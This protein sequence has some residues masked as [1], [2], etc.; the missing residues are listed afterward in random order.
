MVLYHTITFHTVVVTALDACCNSLVNVSPSC[1]FG[2]WVWNCT[3]IQP[4]ANAAFFR[5][6]LY[7]LTQTISQQFHLSQNQLFHF[8][9]TLGV[10]GNYFGR[11]RNGMAALVFPRKPC[12]VCSFWVLG[13]SK[14]LLPSR[15]NGWLL[16]HS[17]DTIK[18]GRSW[19]HTEKLTLLQSGWLII[20]E[21]CSVKIPLQRTGSDWSKLVKNIKI[22]FLFHATLFLNLK[23]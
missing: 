10:T 21:R 22:S 7:K 5:L 16:C 14:C 19:I 3:D 9:Y 12:F 11:K 4:R 20:F 15:E 13:H 17:R 1:V 2:Y 6:G 23:Y 8:S 18:R